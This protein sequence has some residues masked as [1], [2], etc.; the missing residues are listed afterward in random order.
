VYPE[1]FCSGRGQHFQI[2]AS[3]LP[4]HAMSQILGRLCR[5]HSGSGARNKAQTVC[6]RRGWRT[7]VV[8]A[9]REGSGAPLSRFCCFYMVACFYASDSMFFSLR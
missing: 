1:G 2:A 4:L 9:A 3:A 6:M 8:N 5:Q 7:S